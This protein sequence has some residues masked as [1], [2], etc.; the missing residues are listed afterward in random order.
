[1][2]DAL[3]EEVKLNFANPFKKKNIEH[4][5]FAEGKL[6]FYNG[7]ELSDNPY[8]IGTDFFSIWASGWKKAL[9]DRRR[10]FKSPPMRRR[11]IDWHAVYPIGG[12]VT[13]V[14][15][16][17]ACWIYAIASWGFLLGVGLG[18]IPSFFIAIIAGFIWPLI[19]LVLVVGLCVGLCIVAFLL[20]KSW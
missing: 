14:I 8:G 19:A 4:P 5:K 16:F 6:A 12:F 3:T 2:Q 17:I 11:S 18:W 10:I 15:T 9:Q 1:M 13:G 7:L 20:Y